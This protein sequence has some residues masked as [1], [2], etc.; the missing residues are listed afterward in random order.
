VLEE[1]AKYHAEWVRMAKMYV[2][3]VAEDIVQEMYLKINRWGYK[4]I[5]R[6]EVQKA[7][8]FTII[9]GLCLDYLATKN[10]VVKTELQEWHSHEDQSDADLH[11]YYEQHENHIKIR[12]ALREEHNYYDWLFMLYTK[13][14]NPSYRDLAEESG[15]SLM[16]IYN[17]MQKIKEIIKKKL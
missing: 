5:K 1:L 6:G 15:I 3:D 17:D 10:R 13:A 7:Y 2:K 9:R 14:E 12:E 8:I 16:T 4:C 11:R